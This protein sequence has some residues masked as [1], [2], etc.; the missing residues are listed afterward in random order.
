MSFIVSN[1]P[2]D[3]SD[4]GPAGIGIDHKDIT[5]LSCRGNNGYAVFL[6]LGPVE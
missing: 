3:K 2:F 6:K 5:F 1:H 4:D